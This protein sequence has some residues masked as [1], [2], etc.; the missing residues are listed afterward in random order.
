M[1]LA[2]RAE[3]RRRARSPSGSARRCSER[4]GERVEQVEVAGPGFLNLFL[5]DAWYTAAAAHVL[6]AGDG[7]GGGAAAERASGC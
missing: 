3:A 1:L 4:L 6:A 2:P 5:A 7:W